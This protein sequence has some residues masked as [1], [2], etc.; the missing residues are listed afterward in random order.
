MWLVSL[1]EEI[2]TQT[3]SEG[4]HREDI[5][6]RQPPTSQEE[7]P[8][9]RPSLLTA[10]FWPSGLQNRGSE[11]LL[12]SPPVS[13]PRLWQPQ[14][15]RQCVP[16][17][18]WP[19]ASNLCLRTL[20]FE[21]CIIFACH[22]VEFFFLKNWNIIDLQCCVSFRYAVKWF[23]YILYYIHPQNIFFF[24]FFSIISYYRILNIA[25]CAIQ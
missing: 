25:S 11:C 6:R 22:K 14:Q 8:R 16:A 19:R 3:C 5:G 15:R 9:E 10:W 18:M 21:L 7:R 4:R 24:R 20:K 13:G 17:W 1:Q 12:L 23:N 2:R